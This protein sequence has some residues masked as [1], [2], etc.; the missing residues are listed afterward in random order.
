MLLN[1]GH[2]PAGGALRKKDPGGC[3]L[4]VGEERG[5]GGPPS[6]CVSQ[7]TSS[8]PV[9]AGGQRRVRFTFSL[10]SEREMQNGLR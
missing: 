7:G 3:H 10:L 1:P 8:P 2:K 6:P 5:T 4:Q 9:P